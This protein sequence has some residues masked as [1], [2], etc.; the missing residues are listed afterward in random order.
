MKKT[1]F[2]LVLV[3]LL[4][5]GVVVTAVSAQGA[6]YVFPFWGGPYHATTEDDIVLNWAWIAAAPGL[7]KIYVDT[8]YN[9]YTLLDAGGNVVAHLSDPQ[10]DAFWSGLISA[11][12]EETIYDCPSGKVYGSIWSYDL[13]QLPAG[14]YTLVSEVGNSHPVN[15]GLHT[16]TFLDGTPVTTPPSLFP[17]GIDT[18]YVEITVV[19]P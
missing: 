1:L 2:A 5:A 4:A 7:A 8:V 3:A 11:P 10:A 9:E 15:D 16:C 19:E 6:V 12:D 14:T 18:A 17:P 13:G